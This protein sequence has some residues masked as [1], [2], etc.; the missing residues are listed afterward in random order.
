MFSRK[1]RKAHIHWENI[2]SQLPA[3]VYWKNEFGTYLGCNL[4]FAES[5]GLTSENDITGKIDAELPWDKKS[6]AE[7]IDTDQTVLRRKKRIVIEKF[8]R[9]TMKMPLKNRKNKVVGIFGISFDVSKY[10]GDLEHEWRTLDEIIAVMPGHVYWKDR[11]C[12][13]RGGNELQAKDAGFASRKMLIGKTSYELLASH[14]SDTEKKA[15]AELIKNFD[16]KVIQNDTSLT[17]EESIVRSDKSIATYLS[18]RTPLHDEH[19]NVTGLVGISFDITHRKKA[20]ED[21]LIAKEQAEAA[22]RAKTEF[23]EN[24]RHDI[25]TPLTGI[26][27]FARLIQQEAVSEKTKNY[28]DQLVAATT[29]S[30][31]F[32]NEILDAIKVSTGVIPIGDQAFDLKKVA[33]KVIALIKPKAIIKG[34]KIILTYNENL[35]NAVRGDAKR[36]FR[37]LLELVTNALK[38]TAKGEI[39]VA[40]ISENI[41]EQNFLLRCVIADTGLGIALENQHDV[42]LRFKR[43]SPSSDGVYEGTGL[44]RS[45]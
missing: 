7:M 12:L 10:K 25:R 15:Q 20:E 8:N 9:Y 23:L 5:L 37:I 35:P 40:L 32:Q 28:A 18:K 45:E 4:D 29:A 1:K 38:F 34:L 13:L 27:G 43:L 44:G 22:N 36:L 3:S 16:E 33:E 2:F 26:I 39:H 31:D 42:F 17:I 30:L 6:L 21:L 11:N 41:S 19:D 24:I 14:Q